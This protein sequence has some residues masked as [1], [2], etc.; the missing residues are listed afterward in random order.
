[1]LSIIVDD[2]DR[3]LIIA[4]QHTDHGWTPPGLKGDS[5]SDLE[6]Q[7]LAVRTH[8]VQEAK[9]L[10]DSMIEV[11]KFR[12]GEFVNVDLHVFASPI[13]IILYHDPIWINLN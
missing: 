3:F 9:A 12:L 6:L 4:G 5:I 13:R 10:H 11:D 1:M 2:C 8:L 7:H